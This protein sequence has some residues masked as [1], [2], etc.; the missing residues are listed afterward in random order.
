MESILKG[1]FWECVRPPDVVVQLRVTAQCWN[2]GENYGPFSAFFLSHRRSED[3]SDMMTLRK[4]N[5][6]RDWM[7][8]AAT[9]G[10]CTDWACVTPA[11]MTI[12]VQHLCEDH[13]ADTVPSEHHENLANTVG[14]C[15][16][17]L[18]Q[19][20]IDDF[21]SASSD[22]LSP[23]LGEVWR[24][25]IVP[26]NISDELGSATS[27]TFSSEESFEYHE[28]NVWNYMLDALCHFEV[29]VVLGALL[30][31][32]AMGRIALACHFSLDLLCDKT[33]SLPVVNDHVSVRNWPPPP[34]PHVATESTNVISLAAA[35]EPALMQYVLDGSTWSSSCPFLDLLDTFNMRTTATTWNPAGK[36]PGGALLFFL[37][38]IVLTKLCR[39]TVQFS[40]GYCNVVIKTMSQIEESLGMVDLGVWKGE[41][42]MIA[43]IR[44]TNVLCSS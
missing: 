35:N 26:D 11:P 3:S 4:K 36:F 8:N 43:D 12:S 27:S 23:D 41:C 16:T 1:S 20:V 6:L 42:G 31:D 28:Y 39:W 21:N 15:D 2:I 38:R 37:L 10:W 30:D 14:E 7:S 44:V 40:G 34:H 13:D 9:D 24:S 33:F 22:S 25:V 5:M 29:G 17:V 18:V 32:A 19:E